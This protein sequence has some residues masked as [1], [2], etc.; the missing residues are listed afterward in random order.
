MAGFVNALRCIRRV[1][2]C[3]VLPFA[4]A[5]VRLLFDHDWRIVC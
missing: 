2:R 4:C 5:A 3:A 1:L